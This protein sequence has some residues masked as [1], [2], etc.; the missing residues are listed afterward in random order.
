MYSDVFGRDNTLLREQIG[1]K[2]AFFLV[3]DGIGADAISKLA[4]YIEHYRINAYIKCI[5]GGE[6]VKDGLETVL[7]T[8]DA[9]ESFGIDRKE[10]V[11]LVGGGAVLDMGGFAASIAH[12][13][14]EHIRIPTTYLAQVDAG[15]G[16]KN[17]VNYL[18]QKNFIGVFQTPQIVIVDP[19][20]LYTLDERQMRSGMAES[21]KVALMKDKKLFELVESNYQHVLDKHLEHQ[22]TR[23]IMWG[24]IVAHL[25]QI[26]TD[27]Y[28]RQLARPLD[29][30]HEWG[31]RLEIVTDHRLSHGE[32]VSIG[33]AIDSY[34]SSKRGYISEDDFGRIIRLLKNIGLPTF[35]EAATLENIWPGLESFRRHLGGEL[36]ISLLGGIGNKRDV[37]EISKAEVEEALTY[38]KGISTQTFKNL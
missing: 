33:M 4:R 17:A 37:H 14:I 1:N 32:G 19:L 30:G 28:E 13:G 24:T 9:M 8:I 12:R 5:Q 2:K 36:T 3:D 20:F 38:L 10:K 18:G 21:V 22:P 15:I 31:H 27:P 34:I 25:E 16:T 35:D 7:E 29:F 11:V 23:E 26:H 6:Q